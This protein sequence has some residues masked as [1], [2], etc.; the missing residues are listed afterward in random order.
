MQRN[1]RPHKN[2][3]E[4]HDG[5]SVCENRRSGAVIQQHR[6]EQPAP[7]E[8]RAVIAR[9]PAGDT[10]RE[11]RRTGDTGDDERGRDGERYAEQE[12]GDQRRR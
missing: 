10:Q 8:A 11:Q 12:R 5:T 3:D 2:A 7:G 6:R 1:R 4:S 9:Q